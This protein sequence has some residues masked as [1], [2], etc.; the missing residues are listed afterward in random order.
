MA[1]TGLC[2]VIVYCNASARGATQTSTSHEVINCSYYANV[3]EWHLQS[4]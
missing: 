2:G 1:G 3:D 4:L